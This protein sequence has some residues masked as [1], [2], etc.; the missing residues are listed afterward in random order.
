MKQFLTTKLIAPGQSLELKK[1]AMSYSI[2]IKVKTEQ[3]SKPFSK[4][5][6]HKWF[7]HFFNVQCPVISKVGTH[8]L[9]LDSYSHIKVV[10]ELTS[11]FLL[12]PLISSDTLK[13]KFAWI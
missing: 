1:P 2:N 4:V 3:Q 13:G 6:A 11:P 9:V 7:D 10:L 8:V 5:F 12:P